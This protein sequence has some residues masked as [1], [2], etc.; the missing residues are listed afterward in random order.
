MNFHPPFSELRFYN[1][2]DSFITWITGCFIQ[3]LAAAYKITVGLQYFF[4]LIKAIGKYAPP[5]P[6]L[7]ILCVK[8]LGKAFRNREHI[9]GICVLDSELYHIRSDNTALIVDGP[10]KSMQ[11]SF[12]TS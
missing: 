12:T 9:K 3:T 11:Q 7:F 8:I 4:S 2:G 6:Y 1:F 10:E 5:L